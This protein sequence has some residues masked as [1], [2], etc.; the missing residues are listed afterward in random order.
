MIHNVYFFQRTQ[1][2]QIVH[3]Q[4]AIFSKIYL[5]FSI[6]LTAEIYYELFIDSNYSKLSLST[7]QVRLM[8]MAVLSQLG[9]TSS[10]IKTYFFAM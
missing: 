4:I 8:V 5:T 1:S 6:T 7:G 2:A 9:S 3:K 10:D